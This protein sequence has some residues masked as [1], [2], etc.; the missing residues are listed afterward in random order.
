MP[1]LVVLRLVGRFVLSFCILGLASIRFGT[2]A[3]AIRLYP[4]SLVPA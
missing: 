1:V 2:F 4:H 3:R